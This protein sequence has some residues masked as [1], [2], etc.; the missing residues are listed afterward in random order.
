MRIHVVFLLA[1]IFMGLYF[2]V[3]TMEW[4]M[5]VFAIFSVLVSELINTAIELNVD[6]VTKQ[7]RPRAMLAKDVAAGAVFS[8]AIG[9]AIVGCMVFGGRFLALLTTCH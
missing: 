5:L 1:V 9:A 8:A 3:S 6:M 7:Q 2:Q 4:I